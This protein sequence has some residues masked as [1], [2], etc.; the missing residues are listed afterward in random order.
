MKYTYITATGKIEIEVDDQFYAL[1]ISFDRE[2]YNSNRKH[3]RRLPISLENAEYDGGW[4]SDEAD[5]LDDLISMENAELLMKAINQLPH[6]QRTLIREVFFD[7][8][9]PSELARREGVG[10]SAISHRLERA[11]KKLKKHLQ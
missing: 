10:K 4:F 7:E 11:Y 1:L 3:N 5:L 2:E 8:I 9:S 6:K